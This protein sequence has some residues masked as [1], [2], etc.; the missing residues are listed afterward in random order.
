MHPASCNIPCSN[1]SLLRRNYILKITCREISGH[2]PQYATAL[3]LYATIISIVGNT[4][5]CK[6]I[7]S[8]SS[9]AHT[10]RK[11]GRL[12]RMRLCVVTAVVY[13]K[14]ETLL[15]RLRAW[16]GIMRIKT[17][18]VRWETAVLL[19]ILLNSLSLSIVSYKSAAWFAIVE[20]IGILYISLQ[21]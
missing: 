7:C 17:E 18:F 14:V 11:S 2:R 13:L 19:V 5:S 16:N 4:S 1:V 3:L 10:V 9:A 8:S 20:L 21:I 6:K 12:L 15:E